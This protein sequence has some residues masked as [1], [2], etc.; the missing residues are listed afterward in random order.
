MTSCLLNIDLINDFLD[1]LPLGEVEGIVT[2]TNELVQAF[3]LR[4]LPVIWVRQ[5]F[6]PDLSDAFDRPPLS[7]PR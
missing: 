6:D 2:R 4:G 3:R 7:G 5:E 1:R